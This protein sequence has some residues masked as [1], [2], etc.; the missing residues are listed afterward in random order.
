MLAS[1]AADRA[2][3][4]EFEKKIQQLEHSISQLRSA[5]SQVRQ[6]L[7]S[8][9]YP[10]LTLPNEI[11]SEIFIRFLPPYPGFPP[12]T[13]RSSPNRLAEICR[14]WREIALA[15]P[16]LWSAIS[17]FD[18]NRDGQELRVFELWLKRSRHCPL[19]IRLGTDAWASHELVEAVIPHRARWQYLKIKLEGESLPLIDGAMPFLRHLE[20]KIDDDSPP[21]FITTHGVPLL[22]TAIL[23]DVA[24]AH[25]ILPWEQLTS[26]TLLRVFPSECVPILVQTPNLVHCELY[27][28]YNRDSPEHRRD[29]P[30]LCLESLIL[31]KFN[32]PV[33]DFLPILIA[34]ALHSL[35][36]P[37]SFLT[38]K[39]IDSL[40]AFISKS[41]CSLQELHLTG[42]ISVLADSYRQAFP[43][44][45]KLFFGAPAH[46]VD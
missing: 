14:R 32:L 43:S 42:P 36:I 28:C 9:K 3:V 1:L 4:A 24:A 37:E 40:T 17:S 20:L 16:E 23:N 35:K 38:P 6:R 8:Y 19:S 11:T 7:D 21:V 39:P 45:P 15:T 27:V 30:L 34:P 25:V 41:R 5:Q 46:R 31:T 2:R 10:V 44:L 12:L 18:N 33:K 26:L 13:G 29:I 22:R